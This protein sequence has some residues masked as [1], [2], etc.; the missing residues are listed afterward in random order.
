[1]GQVAVEDAVELLRGFILVFHARRFDFLNNKGVATDGALAEDHQ[2]AGQDVGA[3]HG[4]ADRH[5]LVGPCQEVAGAGDHAPAGDHVHSVV[6]HFPHQVCV[7]VFQHRG[8]YRRANAPVQHTGGQ[9]AGC[10]HHVGVAGN[11]FQGFLYAFKLAD[12]AAELLPGVGVGTGRQA[13]QFAGAGAQSG[14]GDGAADGQ[15]FQQHFPA[16]AEHVLAANYLFHG[17]EDFSAPGGAVHEDRVHGQVA[18]TGIHSVGIPRHHHTGDTDLVLLAKQVLGVVN[19]DGEADQRSDRRQGDVAL[20]PGHFQAQ[21]FLAVPF[22]L[23]DDAFV[24]NRASIGAGDRRGQCKAGDF[25]TPGQAR[26]V[27]LFLLVGTIVHQQLAG[28]EGVGHHHGHRRRHAAGGDL[29]DDFGMG[30]VGKTQAAVFFGNH[31]SKEA[32]AANELPHFVRQIVVFVGD[33]PVVQHLAQFFHRAIKKRLFFT[34]QVSGRCI[35]QL[36][37]LR[38]AGKQFAVPVNGAGVE[39]FLFGGRQFW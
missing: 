36:V 23:A 14:Q 32:L 7:A 3:F 22:A 19:L 39:G 8:R 35:Q 34:G 12:G 29:H 28:T 15:A 26:Q 37:P 11:G 21:H 33:L 27:V 20:V 24:R 31:Q 16:L 4:N 18:G 13:G 5:G 17:D 25:F 10:V 38:L 9:Q 30:G 6:D 2:A 1:M